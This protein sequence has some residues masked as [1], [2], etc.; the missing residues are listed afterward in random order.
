MGGG[1]AGEGDDGGD[2]LGVASQL[3]QPLAG[4][5]TDMKDG[6]K[7]PGGVRCFCD[8]AS[9]GVSPRCSR[10]GPAR[11]RPQTHTWNRRGEHQPL[12]TPPRPPLA[13]H[14][15]MRWN[16][17]MHPRTPEAIWREFSGL[18][19]PTADP[20]A[21]RTRPR[22]GGYYWGRP[23]VTPPPAHINANLSRC[24]RRAGAAAFF[25]WGGGR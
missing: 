3:L 21:T 6:S 17:R 4:L 16:H 24:Q 12:K 22:G 2:L 15:R 14:E 10:R 18:C 9:G 5:R 23:G 7:R 11:R 19:P 20:R 13:P 25:T 1:L 8:S